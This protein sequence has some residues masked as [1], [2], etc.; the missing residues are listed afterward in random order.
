MLWFLAQMDMTK[1]AATHSTHFSFPL[2]LADWGGELKYQDILRNIVMT[3][4][5]FSLMCYF[6]I[7][8]QIATIFLEKRQ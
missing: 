5:I 7:H 8:F 6:S 2:T 3:D 1:Q 4:L